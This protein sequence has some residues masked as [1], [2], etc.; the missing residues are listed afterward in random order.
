[1]RSMPRW[2]MVGLLALVMPG[3]LFSEDDVSKPASKLTKAEAAQKMKDDANAPDYCSLYNWYQDDVCDDF[4]RELDPKCPVM[5]TK[6]SATSACPADQFCD[7]AADQCASTEQSGTCKPKPQDCDADFAPVCGCDNKT[8]SNA[9]EAQNAGVAIEKTGECEPPSEDCEL[10]E[11]GPAPGLPNMVCADGQSMSGPTGRC[12]KD[13]AGTCSWEILTCPTEDVCGG[14]LGKECEAGYTCIND[15]GMCQ[16]ADASGVCRLQTN[17]CPTIAQ[18]VCGCDG[19]TYGNRCEAAAAGVSVDTEGECKTEGTSCGGKM[20]NQCGVDEF[21]KYKPEDM[22]GAADQTG[23]CA[24]KP[25]LCDKKLAPVCGCDGQTYDNACAAEFNGISVASEGACG[26]EKVC[27]GIAGTSCGS[28]SEYCAYPEGTCKVSDQQG[29]CKPR[30][31]VCRTGGDPICGCDGK[32]YENECTAILAGVSVN[33]KGECKQECSPSNAT[34]CGRGKFC[35]YEV[36]SCRNLMREGLCEFIPTVCRL[37]SDPVCGCDGKTYTN[38]C[39]ADRAQVQISSLG[40]CRS[41]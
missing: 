28:R 32:T 4:C 5:A 33:Y 19:K 35:R 31:V 15:D 14:L 30:P 2:C 10:A 36:G 13:D 40:A 22:C 21:C 1:M 12:L 9:C 38:Q 29:V 17:T 3:C 16:V 24:P 25:A 11:C 26:Q 39:E 20:G 18:P 34:L 41:L 37:V 6:C 8:Y 27:G 7:I 23:T